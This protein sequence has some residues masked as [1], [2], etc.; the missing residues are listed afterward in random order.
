[1]AQSII[2][3]SKKAFKYTLIFK[4]LSQGLG[5][6]ATLLLVRGLSEHD[7]GIYNLLYA[8]ISIIG[9]ISSFGIVDSLQRYIPEYYE[10]GEFIIA[11]NLYRTA[12]FIRLISNVLILGFILLLWD[13]LAPVLK[14][15]GYK[16]YFMIFTLVIILHMQRAMLE[17]CL[18]SYFLH[19]YS[20]AIGILFPLIKAVGYGY[21]IIFE[22]SL[23]S[24]ILIDTLAYLIIFI[25]LQLLYYNKIP[26][27][28]GLL[29]QFSK[30]E[31]KRVAKYALFYNF[32]NASLGLL[33]ANFD[34]FIIA[35]LLNPVAVGGYSFCIRLTRQI[36]VLLPFHFFSDV[37]TPSFFS[38]S[39][40]SDNFNTTHFFQLVLKINSILSV[41][42]LFFLVLYGDNI[43]ITLFNGKFIEYSNVLCGTF[44]FS[45][46]NTLPVG[47]IA[48]LR[49]RADIILYSK[50]FA[51]YNLIADLILIKM[52]G[53]WG[54]VIATGTANLG[55]KLFVWYFVKKEANFK[56]MKS[57]FVKL[58]GIWGF[59]TALLFVM[60]PVID[61]MIELYCGILVFGIAFI[62]QFKLNY[63][64]GTEKKFISNL[65]GNDRR[66]SHLKRIILHEDKKTL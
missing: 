2:K 36:N 55:K 43:I 62:F 33:D 42:I 22:K 11:H 52:F 51:F 46:F 19:K 41:P 8:I 38:A 64:N 44:F 3:K 65:I 7:Y 30:Q 47:L 37:I 29:T 25:A 31:K 57:F 34:N 54:A 58:I 39:T 28:M 1:M 35:M 59:V 56:K 14:L 6:I 21:I 15:N 32:N 45:M 17:T 24:T 9:M 60:S 12:S 10:K 50:V 66:F 5:F 26:A 18:S 16:T 49:E 13:T 4:T 61:Q 27:S 48:Q 63:F 20:K 53:I 23:L 40:L